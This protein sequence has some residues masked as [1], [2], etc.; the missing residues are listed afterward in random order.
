VDWSFVRDKRF[1]VGAVAA[2][3]L[4][5]YA[6][7]QKRK[8]GGTT[9]SD[10]STVTSGSTTGVNPG[11]LNTTGTDV[12]SWMGDYSAGLQ[13]QLTD[14][15][16]QLTDAVTALQNLQPSPDTPTTPTTLPAVKKVTVEGGSW[17]KDVMTNYH[18]DQDLLFKL[19]PNIAQSLSWA[20]AKGFDQAGGVQVF[21]G[22]TSINVP[23]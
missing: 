9:A 12:A 23:Q 15:G 4:G 16:K 18:V 7:W 11:Y 21:G 17:L 2:V 19:N 6:F 1:Q 13:Q 5:G 10:T 20:S 3:A 14:Y 8:A 22:P